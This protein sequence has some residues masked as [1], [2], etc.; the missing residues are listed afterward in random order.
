MNPTAEGILAIYPPISSNIIISS[1]TPNECK[2]SSTVFDIIGGPQR[3]QK[4]GAPENF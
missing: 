2:R 1:S 3:Y 4:S